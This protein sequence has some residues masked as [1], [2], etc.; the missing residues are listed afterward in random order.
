MICSFENTE[1]IVEFSV[2]SA[3]LSFLSDFKKIMRLYYL[4]YLVKSPYSTSIM[5][6]EK[7][8]NEILVMLAFWFDFRRIRG[9][10]FFYKVYNLKDDCWIVLHISYIQ[11]FFL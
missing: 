2:Y 1:L 5:Y 10:T 6:C 11:R 7:I 4:Y 3:S 8:L 9:I